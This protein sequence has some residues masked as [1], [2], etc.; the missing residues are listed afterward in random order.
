MCRCVERRCA[1]RGGVRTK[2]RRC[3]GREE[4]GRGARLVGAVTRWGVKGRVAKST[5]GRGR[6]AVAITCKNE[7]REIKYGSYTVPLERRAC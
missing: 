2:R 7:G 1:G 6:C 3:E 5:R 4:S